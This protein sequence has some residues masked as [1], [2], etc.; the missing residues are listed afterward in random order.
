[1]VA[2]MHTNIILEPLR[3]PKRW[4]GGHQKLQNNGALFHMKDNPS[5]HVDLVIL[6]YK[7]L[8]WQIT[9]TIFIVF[10]VP[11]IFLWQSLPSFRNCLDE[12]VAKIPS[13]F[14]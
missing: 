9:S 2:R 8:L 4:D 11:I 13:L 6:S 5:S 3:P 14:E 7:I 1:M 10:I 12:N